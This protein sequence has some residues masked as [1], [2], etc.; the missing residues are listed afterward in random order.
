M[1]V[2]KLRGMHDIKTMSGAPRKRVERKQY[3]QQ[4]QRDRGSNFKAHTL[5]K[6]ELEMKKWVTE[7]QKI[8]AI[9]EKSER[10]FEQL[11]ERMGYGY[12]PQ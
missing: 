10:E 8:D 3:Q 5:E 7:K 2:Y 9:W 11:C 4:H 6:F 12:H 1:R